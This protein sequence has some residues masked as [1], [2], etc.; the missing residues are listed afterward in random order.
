MTKQF[1]AEDHKYH[2]KDHVATFSDFGFIK[3]LDFRQPGSIEYAI[4]FIFEEDH[5]RLHISGDLG[6]LIAF[7]QTNMTFEKFAKDYLKN[8]GYFIDKIQTCSR[9]IYAYDEDAARES[10]IE[11][12]K[13]EGSYDV[14]LS[15]YTRYGTDEKQAEEDMLYDFMEDFD[16]RTGMSI[17]GIEQYIEHTGC[18]SCDA[19]AMA[20]DLGKYDTGII[21]IYL[22]AFGLAMEQLR[23]QLGRS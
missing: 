23:A 11:T 16:E 4:R 17:N 18:D 6:E 1:N 20:S 13:L 21:D 7:N 9:P 5:Y 15:D 3:V 19:Y 14:A 12:M 8:P 22:M 10:L 2:F